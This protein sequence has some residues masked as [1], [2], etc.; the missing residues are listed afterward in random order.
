MDKI[1]VPVELIILLELGSLKVGGLHNGIHSFQF[2]GESSAHNIVLGH[3]SYNRGRFF[4]L[5]AGFCLFG[6]FNLN[7]PGDVGGVGYLQHHLVYSFAVTDFG[8][9]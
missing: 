9:A 3:T 7:L 1:N 5:L 8:N 6:S 4:A 2:A